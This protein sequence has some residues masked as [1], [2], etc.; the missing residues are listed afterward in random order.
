MFLADGGYGFDKPMETGWPPPLLQ[1]TVRITHRDFILPYWLMHCSS[2]RGIDIAFERF[3]HR[4]VEGL[5][6]VQST[7]L[8]WRN[9]MWPLVVSKWVF[10]GMMSLP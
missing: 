8:A 1:V 9:S 7:A 10:P 3:D 6:T 4:V 5:S 2:F